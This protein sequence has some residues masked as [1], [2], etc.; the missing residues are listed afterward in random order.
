MPNTIIKQ[1]IIDKK[2]ALTETE[3]KQLLKEAGI[4]VVETKLANSKEE[5]I[6]ISREIGFPVALKVV[7]PDIL[8]KS[9]CGGV[10]LSLE[11]ETQVGRSFTD[12]IT[13]AKQ[14]NPSALI[15]GV[16]V[17]KMIKTGVEVIMG[18]SK[19]AQFGPAIMF[20]IGGVFVEV[21]N[22]VSFG[23]V[24]IT[25]NDAA[26]MIKEIKG[27]PILNG[28]RGQMPVNIASLENMLL[29]L[30]DFIKKT[31]EIK[32]LDLNPVFVS[33]DGPITADARVI[34]ELD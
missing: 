5:A 32:E 18:M 24:P 34:L 4:P 21:L 15:Q 14:A 27:Y 20:G 19:D 25:K 12:I 2:T 7:S 13:A 26:R 23:I 33:E 31:P 30:S 9:D 29:N 16:S 11:D 6:S 10:H 17:Q 1:A 3:S 8:H 28:Y 22:D